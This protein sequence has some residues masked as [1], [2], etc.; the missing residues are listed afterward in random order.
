MKDKELLRKSCRKRK[1]NFGYLIFPSAQK[2]EKVSRLT[3]VRNLF[4]GYVV[5]KDEILN[6]QI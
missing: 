5:L 1:E 6:I 3:A 2:V 4:Y